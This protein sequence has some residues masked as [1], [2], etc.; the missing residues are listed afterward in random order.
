MY[1]NPNKRVSPSSS[2]GQCA[3]DETV[4]NINGDIVCIRY[5]K[6]EVEQGGPFDKFLQSVQS[7]SPTGNA[8]L[9]SVKS[10]TDTSYNVPKV[11]AGY[12]TY[13]YKVMMPITISNTM[14][15]SFGTLMPAS[16]G[17]VFANA[18]LPS[19]IQMPT[20]ETPNGTNLPPTSFFVAYR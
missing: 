2:G 3:Q 6:D 12:Y 19:G 7:D 20:I 5:N 17:V 16:L 11:L 8:F 10:M 1:V 4:V 18:V 13:T 14:S 9:A 15:L